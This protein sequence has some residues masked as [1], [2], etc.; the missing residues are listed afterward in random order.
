MLST[1]YTYSRSTCFSIHCYCNYYAHL[2]LHPFVY[3]DGIIQIT[4]D[5]YYLST[6]V[7]PVIPHSNVRGDPRCHLTCI[8]LQVSHAPSCIAD[9]SVTVL[10]GDALWYLHILPLLSSR[11]SNSSRMNF[12]FKTSR[13]QSVLC[14]AWRMASLNWLYSFDTGHRPFTK[15]IYP[16]KHW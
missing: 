7:H 8:Y 3:M 15:K 5:F 16:T 4:V 10:P 12:K 1:R 2:F 6:C 9:G 11:C 13:L 14:K